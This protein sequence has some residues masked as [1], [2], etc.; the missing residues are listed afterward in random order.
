VQQRPRRPAYFW[1]KSYDKNYRHK[2]LLVKGM[3]NSQAIAYLFI[4]LALAVGCGYE[5]SRTEDEARRLRQSD[6]YW[7]RKKAKLDDANEIKKIKKQITWLY[8]I[9]LIVCIFFTLWIVFDLLKFW[10]KYGY[11]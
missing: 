11:I 10:V 5:L 1:H 7:Y 3:S 8:S 6:K 9:I 4:F 2:L